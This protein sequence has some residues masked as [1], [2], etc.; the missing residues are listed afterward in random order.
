MLFVDGE[1]YTLRGQ[2]VA[3]AAGVTLKTG[4]FFEDGVHLWLPGIPATRKL[5]GGSYP[6]QYSAVRA[7]Y[8]T[9]AVG[10]DVRLASVRDA[11]WRIGFTAA[12]FKKEK[13]T[14]RSKGV[15]ISLATDLLSYGFKGAYDVAVLVA[16][17]RDYVPLIQEVK[18]LGRSV[19]VAFFRTSGLNPDLRLHADEFLEFEDFFLKRWREVS[20]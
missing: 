8:Y 10:D 20:K 3:A 17:D 7:H 1:N 19:S 18:R 16:G 9:S 4:E 12:V 2:E 6:L 14:G 13:Q 15:D 5:Y 11:L